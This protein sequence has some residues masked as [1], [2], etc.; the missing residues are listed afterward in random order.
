MLWLL[1]HV[2]IG[3]SRRALALPVHPIAPATA[4]AAAAAA[5]LSFA[6]R[7]AP[8]DGDRLADLFRDIVG[9]HFADRL[10]VGFASLFADILMA[11]RLRMGFATVAS[12]TPAPAP[13]AASSA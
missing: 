9:G 5:P 2:V 1:V 6:L 4:A 3:R 7:L 12:A 13:A 10:G 8:V 11:I